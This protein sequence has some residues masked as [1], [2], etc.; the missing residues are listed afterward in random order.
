MIQELNKSEFVGLESKN[1]GF[2]HSLCEKNTILVCGKRVVFFSCGGSVC[3]LP[4][5]I[6][7]RSVYF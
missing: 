3:Y 4:T 5:N 7:I 1:V 2:T 6:E